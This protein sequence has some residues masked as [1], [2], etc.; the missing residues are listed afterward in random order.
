MQPRRYKVICLCLCL[1]L[2]AL[3]GYI[4]SSRALQGAARARETREHEA[5]GGRAVAQAQ[6]LGA[7]PARSERAGDRR[8]PNVRAF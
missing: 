6:N 7:G 2:A 4:V 3:S 1:C 5:T 8:G